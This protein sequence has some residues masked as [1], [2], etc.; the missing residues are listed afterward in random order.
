MKPYAQITPHERYALSLLRRQG[1]TQAAIARVLCRHPSTIG[2]ALRRNVWREDGRTYRPRKAQSYTNQRR[3]VSRRN[4]QFSAA[5]WALVESVLREDFSP[6]Q[7]VGWFTR[8]RILT[9]SHETIYRYI[10]EDKKRGGTLH[11]HLRRANQ[12]VRKRYGAYDRR[13]RL[14]GKRHIS[15][16]PAGAAN[17][18]RDGH[19][20]V[21]TVLGNSQS[22]ACIVTLVER[23]CGFTV[24]GKLPRRAA[25]ELNW[26][27]EQLI[28]RQ[29]RLVRTITADHGTEFHSYTA[30]E[31]RVP[32]RF[33]FATPH[34][35][36]ERGTNENTN[37]LIR[38]YLPKGVSMEHITQEDCDRIATKLNRRPRKRYHWHTPAELYAA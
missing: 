7:V 20:E 19:W 18:S 4:S 24:I 11:G 30:L 10:G 35:S 21:D 37:G 28:A 29:P 15:T 6:A 33:Y 36:W 2:R 3:R 14:A 26:R 27:L 16:R 5:D 38:Q 22:G 23:K 13:G 17:R 9:I 12:R 1:Y 8:F 32:A 34:H 25:P 31:Q